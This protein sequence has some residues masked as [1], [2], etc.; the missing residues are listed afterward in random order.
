MSLRHGLTL[1]AMIADIVTGSV[2]ILLMLTLKFWY[3]FAA[4]AVIAVWWKNGGM[5]AWNPK[6][7]KELKARGL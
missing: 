1:M 3:F 4:T 6:T 7:W 2:I 5:M